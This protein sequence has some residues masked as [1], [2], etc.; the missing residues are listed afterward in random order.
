MICHIFRY[1]RL[2][3]II[4]V[5]ICPNKFSLW[6]FWLLFIPLC[7]NV[8][9]LFL[10]HST[11]NL[12]TIIFRYWGFM[13]WFWRILSWSSG[14]I[15][16]FL[17]HYVDRCRFNDVHVGWSPIHWI[18]DQLIGAFCY[19]RLHT[20]NLSAPL[21]KIIEIHL[22]ST[23]SMPGPSIEPILCFWYGQ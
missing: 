2:A 9:G 18:L 21:H 11:S 14:L 22:F 7:P 13:L 1:N 15:Q 23:V 3:S 20:Y 5:G 17:D 8:G 6:Q 16:H 19:R 10:I 12:G 4:M